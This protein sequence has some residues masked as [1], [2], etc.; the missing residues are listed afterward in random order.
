MEDAARLFDVNSILVTDVE[1]ARE[2]PQQVARVI[3]QP[4]S[5]KQLDDRKGLGR[6]RFSNPTCVIEGHESDDENFPCAKFSHLPG[7][8]RGPYAPNAIRRTRS[9]LTGLIKP[10]FLIG[11]VGL[12]LFFGVKFLPHLFSF[13]DFVP[14]SPTT[15]STTNTGTVSTTDGNSNGNSNPGTGNRD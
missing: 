3:A 5:T 12:A 4:K 13:G 15:V 1:I 11:F 10:V 2:I 8:G 7:N 14:K 9:F 6:R